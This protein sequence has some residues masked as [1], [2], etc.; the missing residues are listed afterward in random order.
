M[1][2]NIYNH[3]NMKNNFTILKVVLIFFS[4]L[5]SFLKINCILFRQIN[6]F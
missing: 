3:E 5:M 2:L 4:R 6:T 1:K